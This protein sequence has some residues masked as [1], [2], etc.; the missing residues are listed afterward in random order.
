[1]SAYQINVDSTKNYRQHPKR[2]TFWLHYTFHHFTD[3]C[4]G[5]KSLPQSLR[6]SFATFHVLY[7]CACIRKR[8]PPN[9]LT[10]GQRRDKPWTP[11]PGSGSSRVW[12]CRRSLWDECWLATSSSQSLLSLSPVGNHT[13]YRRLCNT[14]DLPYGPNTSWMCQWA[15]ASDYYT[16][17]WIAESIALMGVTSHG[18][19]N[20]IAQWVKLI[21]YLYHL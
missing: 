2:G 5:E 9:Y 13:M 7:T 6:V 10:R 1:M 15:I 4:V 17:T 19:Y 20:D 11:C 3:C 12:V 16:D 8:T 21:R 18:S 14:W